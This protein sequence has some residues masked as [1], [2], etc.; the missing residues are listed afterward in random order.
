MCIQCQSR[1]VP[2]FHD[3]TERN[4]S[5]S[6][7]DRSDYQ[8][9]TFN[10]IERTAKLNGRITALGRFMSCSVKKCLPFFRAM[11]NA[12][13]FE[14]NDDCQKAL[15]EIKKFLTSPPLLSRPTPG[16]T[17]YLYLSVGNEFIASVLIRED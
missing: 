17:L 9:E 7:K 13:K 11:K 10:D 15:G 3:L 14:W 4:R 12:K 2:R 5:E 1:K 16:E 6:E 8:N